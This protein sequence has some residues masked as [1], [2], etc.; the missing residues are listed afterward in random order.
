MDDVDEQTW[1]EGDSLLQREAAAQAAVVAAG[2]ALLVVAVAAWLL[3]V[4]ALQERA[5][6][7]PDAATAAKVA[8]QCAAQRQLA[9]PFLTAAAGTLIPGGL[10]L[11]ASVLCAVLAGVAAATSARPRLSALSTVAHAVAGIAVLLALWLLVQAARATASVT[12]EILSG[13][14]VTTTPS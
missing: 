6:A 8:Q 2:V 7:A 11:L 14:Q 1:D 10:A 12:G 3:W 5:C 13:G 9:S 4:A